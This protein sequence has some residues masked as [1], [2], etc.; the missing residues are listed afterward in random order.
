MCWNC[1]CTMIYIIVYTCKWNNQKWAFVPIM[2]VDES[3]TYTWD[4]MEDY[5]TCSGGWMGE[6][7]LRC[8]IH[9]ENDLVLTPY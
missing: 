1:P 4:L 5:H 8:T 9:D 7:P 6:N 2:F 3:L